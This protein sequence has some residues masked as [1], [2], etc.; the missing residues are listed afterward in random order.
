MVRP[1]PK[2]GMQGVIVNHIAALQKHITRNPKD[3]H[4]IKLLAARKSQLGSSKT[5]YDP[6]TLFLKK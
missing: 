4:A 6:V 2:D 1:N 3:T 5:S